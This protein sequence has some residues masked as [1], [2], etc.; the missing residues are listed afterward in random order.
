MFFFNFVPR[1]SPFRTKDITYDRHVKPV[2]ERMDLL[3]PY[4]LKV[5]L[6]LSHFTHKNTTKTN[7]KTT[8]SL[9]SNS[10][11]LPPNFNFEL[12]PGGFIVLSQQYCATFLLLVRDIPTARP[13]TTE[14]FIFT[15][16]SAPSSALEIPVKSGFPLPPSSNFT[17][18]LQIVPQITP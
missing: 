1:S 6:F 3:H 9:Q 12:R 14:I 4:H 11:L 2:N 16:K 15:T 7:T 8:S 17:H 10:E 5:Y 13:L 18:K